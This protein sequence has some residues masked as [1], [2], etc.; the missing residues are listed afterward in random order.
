[1]SGFRNQAIGKASTGYVSNWQN[2][3][4]WVKVL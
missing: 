1:V 4:N 2:W 3:K